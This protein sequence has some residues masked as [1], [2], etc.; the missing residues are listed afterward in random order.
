MNRK[1]FVLGLAWVV[2]AFG[3]TPEDAA[4]IKYSNQSLVFLDVGETYTYTL[5]DGRERRISLKSVT[6]HADSVM[7][8]MRRAEVL[9]EIDRDPLKLVREPYVMPTEIAGLRI[10]ADTTSR[11]MDLPKRVQFSLWD[12]SDPIVDT[13]LFVFPLAGYGLFSQGTQGYNEPVHLGHRDGD[14]AGQRFY[15]NYGFDMAGFEGRDEVVACVEGTV[16]GAYPDVGTLL[17]EDDRGIV[18]EYGHMEKIL[19]EVKEGLKVRR[20]QKV[21][22]LGRKGGSGNFSHLHVGVYLSKDDLAAGR[23]CRNL[24]LYP[25]LMEAFRKASGRTL[26]AVARPHHAVRTGETVRFDGA[27]SLSYGSKI[28]TFRWE[29]HDGTS[30]DSARA[31]KVYDRPGTYMAALYVEDEKGLRDVDFCKVKVYSKDKV[32]D[33]MPI[34]FLTYSPSRGV[35]VGQTVYFR[36]WP[37]GEEAGAIRIDFGDGTVIEKYAPYSEVRHSFQKP[38]IHIV[39]ATTTAAGFSVTQKLKVI[40][41]P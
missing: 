34:F 9:V 30:A 4:R 22:L 19:P 41:E 25:W 5:K 36:G 17:L 39:T 37:Q 11:W 18:F 32:E 26:F 14:P 6:E 29:F 40:V 27:R 15:H 20:G 8:L 33:V 28:K 2:S 21:G 12:A 1:A 13:K 24:N 3:I 10:Q 35:R 7:G 31:E 23:T 16:I 38:G